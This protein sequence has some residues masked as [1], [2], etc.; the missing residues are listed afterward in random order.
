MYEHFN[1]QDSLEE[2]ATEREKSCFFTGHRNIVTDKNDL[3]K[4]MRST[5]AYLY[6]V[7]VNIFH[8]GG[9]LGFDTLAAAQIIDMRRTH[10]NMKLILNLPFLNQDALW[11]DDNKRFYSYIISEADDVCYVSKNEQSVK[12]QCSKF[13]LQRN[14]D[15]A[16]CS[17]YCIA[18]YSGK[19][20][21]T[22]YT[23]NYAKQI[24]CE[25][26]NLYNK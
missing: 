20:G 11:K 12:N 14:R 8:T 9:A 24:G 17:K 22:S 6:S 26:Y 18:Y 3:L 25:V 7:G 19:K 23:I 5:I 15:M 2:Y 13:Y 16:D 1:F 21:G 4:T 10:E